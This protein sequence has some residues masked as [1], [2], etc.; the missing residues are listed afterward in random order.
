MLIFFFILHSKLLHLNFQAIFLN[1]PLFS[2]FPPIISFYSHQV[3]IPSFLFAGLS[4]I[5]GRLSF[6]MLLT[7]AESILLFEGFTFPMLLI[8]LF[9]ILLPF[10]FAEFFVE[11][12]FSQL[13]FVTFNSLSPSDIG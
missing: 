3:Q 4:L 10:L 11:G 1:L 9:F 6:D 5:L 12:E 7:F 2:H 8:L 13:C